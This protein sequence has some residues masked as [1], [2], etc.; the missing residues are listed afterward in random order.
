MAIEYGGL[1]H[2]VAEA[3]NM[4]IR[5]LTEIYF[6]FSFVSHTFLYTVLNLHFM[7]LCDTLSPL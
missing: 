7:F 4:E 3:F 2:E 5:I 6:L 1:Y